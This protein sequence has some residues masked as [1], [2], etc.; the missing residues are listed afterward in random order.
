[1]W[2]SRLPVASNPC[3]FQ[4]NR[5]KKVA[6]EIHG[7]ILC[8]KYGRHQKE[9]K[10]LKEYTSFLSITGIPLELQEMKNNPV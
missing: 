1:M 7:L 4:P 9:K 10:K 8:K 6:K 2:N 3:K 5:S